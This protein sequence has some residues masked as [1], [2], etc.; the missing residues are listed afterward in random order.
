MFSFIIINT[1]AI[2][3]NKIVSGVI[4]DAITMTPIESVSINLVDSNLS[5]ISNAEGKYRITIPTNRKLKFSH[6]GYKPFEQEVKDGTTELEIYLEPS[7]LQLDEVIVRSKPVKELLSD[8]VTASKN[9]L[10][11]SILIQS[12]YREFVKVDNQ[13]TNFSDGLLD[14]NVKR[15]SGASDLYVKQSRAYKLMDENTNEREKKREALYF[16]DVKDAV[17]EAYNFRDISRILNSKSY[18][19]EIETKTDDKGNSIEIVTILPKEEVVLHLFSGTVVFDAKTNLILEMDIKKSP[20]HLDYAQ[21]LNAVFFRFKVYEQARKSS[22]RID[23][24]KYILVY[25]Q[26]KLNV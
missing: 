4:I 6:L 19:F 11:K 5:T 18:D 25:N 13:Y 7:T 2:A 12:Y 1:T 24:D 14:Y 26:N 22:F 15:K 16:Y 8:A 9:K 17:S 23:G 3:Q 10:E 20:K 21:E